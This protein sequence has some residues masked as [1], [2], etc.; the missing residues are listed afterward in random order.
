MGFLRKVLILLLSI[1]FVILVVG[2]GALYFKQ[3]GLTGHDMDPGNQTDMDNDK[4]N[5]APDQ[6]IPGKQSPRVPTP[7]EIAQIEAAFLNQYIEDINRAIGLVNQAN[8]LITSDPFFA[9]PPVVDQDSLKDTPFDNQ[10]PAPAPDTKKSV[11]IL[12][13]GYVPYYQ[14]NMKNVHRGIY[15]LAQGMTLMNQILDRMNQDVSILRKNPNYLPPQGYQNPGYYPG[16]QVL[17]PQVIPGTNIPSDHGAMNTNIFNGQ[18]I[19][20]GLYLFLILMFLVA[21]VAIGGFVMSL[22]RKKPQNQD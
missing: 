10:G 13:E 14:E 16:A 1:L 2:G 6:N 8:G 7:Q 15:R 11:I 21:F 3:G 19:T 4:D 18:T 17:P 20:N 22:F 12:P 5:Q 9:N